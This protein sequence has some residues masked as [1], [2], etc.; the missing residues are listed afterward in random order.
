MLRNAM[1]TLSLRSGHGEGISI[2]S[3]L[4]HPTCGCHPKKTW[5]VSIFLRVIKAFT[6]TPRI[7]YI[8]HLFESQPKTS[9]RFRTLQNPDKSV[10]F[11]A[12]AEES[13]EVFTYLSP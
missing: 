2:F 10:N 7:K 4:I 6:E 1:L 13:E 9:R 8:H 5:Y 3:I 12:G 11:S